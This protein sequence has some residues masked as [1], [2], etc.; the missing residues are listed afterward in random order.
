MTKWKLQ[1]VDKYGKVHD[2]TD[3]PSMHEHLVNAGLPPENIRLI[4]DEPEIR[5]GDYVRHMG[6]QVCQVVQVTQHP[7]NNRPWLITE[8][9]DGARAGRRPTACYADFASA[10]TKLPIERLEDEKPLPW[11][12]RLEN[13]E[14]TVADHDRRL[15]A[16]AR[17]LKAAHK[18]F[19]GVLQ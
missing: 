12:R 9:R 6:G 15:D 5:V 1:I 17:A 11:Q 4:E 19:R 7:S 18:I 13:L 10:F 14:V 8:I 2:L 3:L 16:V